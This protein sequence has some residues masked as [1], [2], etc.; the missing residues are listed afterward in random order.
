VLACMSRGRSRLIVG[1]LSINPAFKNTNSVT[2]ISLAEYILKLQ[3]Q[4]PSRTVPGFSKSSI[5]AWNVMCS[6]TRVFHSLLARSELLILVKRRSCILALGTAGYPA[7]WTMR[8]RGG[9]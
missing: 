9:L 2:L 8:M 7:L 5:R 6:K 1:R 3:G 4:F